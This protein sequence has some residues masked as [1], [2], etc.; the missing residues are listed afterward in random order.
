MGLDNFD[1]IDSDY[2]SW[3]IEES[4]VI[5]LDLEDLKGILPVSKNQASNVL[6]LIFTLLFMIRRVRNLEV[7]LIFRF[8]DLHKSKLG[9][10]VLKTDS[11]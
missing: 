1:K 11:V 10:H 5:F 3:M 9:E 6:D 7:L 4:F 8:I 2:V